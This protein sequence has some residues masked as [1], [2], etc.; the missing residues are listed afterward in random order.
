MFNDIA[1]GAGAVSLCCALAVKDSRP[2]PPWC[3]A[4]AEEDSYP[5]PPLLTPPGVVP[6]L[7]PDESYVSVLLIGA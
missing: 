4:S 7:S 5:S 1:D 6:N 3:C 2:S